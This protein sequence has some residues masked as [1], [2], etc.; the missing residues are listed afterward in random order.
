M[1]IAEPDYLEMWRELVLKGNQGTGPRFNKREQAEEYDQ[2]SKKRNKEKRDV[3]MEL[4]INRLG[5]TDTVLDVGAGTGRWAIQLA[6]KASRVTAVEPAGAMSDILVSNARKEGVSEKIELIKTGWETAETAMADVVICI[7]AMYGSSDF[8]SFIRKMEAHAQRRCYLG[9]RLFPMD[10]IIQ[11]LCKKIYGTIHDSPNFFVAYNA[12]L[13]M[14]IFAD[15]VMDEIQ[16][17]WNNDSLEG[18]FIRAKKHLNL[19]D[20]TTYNAL[21]RDTLKR[22]LVFKDG[23]FW[24][25]DGMGTALVSWNVTH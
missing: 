17:T 1:P 9:L 14:G 20:S 16:R 4:V 19:N 23:L 3:L 7:H 10:G 6:K 2:A 12:L 21:I 11:E 15:V 8:V 24:W 22:R 18:A 13:Q 5:S 25:P